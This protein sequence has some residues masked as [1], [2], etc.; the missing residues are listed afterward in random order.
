VTDPTDEQRQR[1]PR[2][3]APLIQDQSDDASTR[4]RWETLAAEIKPG[5][6]RAHIRE[7][8]RRL[9]KNSGGIDGEI[10]EWL[11][12]V[13]E[14]D[15]NWA[16]VCHFERSPEGERFSRSELRRIAPQ[17]PPT[18]RAEAARIHWE[19]LLAELTPGATKEQV[20]ET[21]RSWNIPPGA[22]AASGRMAQWAHRLDGDWVLNITLRKTQN[23]YLL[24]QSRI[25]PRWHL[26]FFERLL[27][28]EER[29]GGPTE[30][31]R[32][33]HSELVQEGKRLLDLAQ[34][35]AKYREVL[36][37]DAENLPAAFYLHM[38]NELR[39]IGRT[40]AQ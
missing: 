21:L 39:D 32:R 31:T 17:A 40:V 35:E 4:P 33:R 8:L 28:V 5:M 29:Q 38:L 14:L 11:F 34:A 15:E 25:S 7:I 22:G 19:P 18:P 23:D 1:V 20:R 16:L 24:S 27:T 9:A 26:P 6:S 2:K 36:A 3:E 12:S 30:E 37:A 10:G 13:Y